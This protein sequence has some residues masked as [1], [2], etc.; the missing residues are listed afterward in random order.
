MS[1]ATTDGKELHSRIVL[2]RGWGEE[3]FTFYTNYNSRKGVDLAANP[4]ASAVFYWDPVFR[5]VCISGKVT[6][7]A[8]ADS[9]KYWNARE[10]DSQISQY[11]SHQSQEVKSREELEQNWTKAEQEFAG[12]AIPCPAHWGGYVLVPRKIEFWIGR[13][14]RLH[15]RYEF[16]RQ[17]TSWSFRRLYP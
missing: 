8:R 9:E 13:P 14:G 7:T 3:G 16:Q 5:Q 12:K 11:V 15:D 4:E 6:K 17:K 10:R 2:C 1:L